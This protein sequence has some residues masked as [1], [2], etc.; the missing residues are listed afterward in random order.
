VG[1]V[2][3]LIREHFYIKGNNIRSSADFRLGFKVVKPQRQLLLCMVLHILA[4]AYIFRIPDYLWQ[5]LQQAVDV[6]AGLRHGGAAAAAVVGTGHLLRTFGQ[7]RLRRFTVAP[8][9]G[10]NGI[11]IVVRTGIA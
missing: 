2:V 3:V 4:A 9:G 11:L 8:Q 1:P 5:H 6:L 7:R 10:V